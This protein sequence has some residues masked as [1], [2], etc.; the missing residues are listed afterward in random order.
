LR[1]REFSAVSAQDL[2]GNPQF[3]P[4]TWPLAGIW[5]TPRFMTQQD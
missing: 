5:A 4:A 3:L 2:T 1:K